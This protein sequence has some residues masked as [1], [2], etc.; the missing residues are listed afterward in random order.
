MSSF[1]CE[2]CNYKDTHLM[3]ISD[4]QELGVKITLKVTKA[5][6][7]NLLITEESW[8]NFIETLEMYGPINSFHMGFSSGISSSFYFE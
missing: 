4:I 3:P 6:V 1:I 7:N 8:Q 2:E 5:E